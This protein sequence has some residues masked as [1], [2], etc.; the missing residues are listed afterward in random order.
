[1]TGDEHDDPRCSGGS[2]GVEHD[3]QP[4][5]ARHDNRC[6]DDETGDGPDDGG[7]GVQGPR[8]FGPDYVDSLVAVQ[9]APAADT[10]LDLLAPGLHQRWPEPR[11]L[12]QDHV[13]WT[14]D[15]VELHL[16]AATA[17]EA[18]WLLG[19][20]LGMA[21]ALHAAAAR[22]EDAVTSTGLRRA[23]ASAGVLMISELDPGVW[24]ESTVL[25]R[26]LRR[27]ADDPDRRAR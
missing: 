7:A 24:I 11:V 25:V 18:R 26:A 27:I 5:D 8:T 1:M 19:V 20:V 12:W 22:D 6:P 16:D 15:R 2:D 17:D 21:P 9:D 23:L 14:R 10:A 3:R 13:W 4:A